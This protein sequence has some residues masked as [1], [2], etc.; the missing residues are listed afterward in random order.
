VISDLLH[1]ILG[2]PVTLRLSG[3][4]NESFSE[5]LENRQFSLVFALTFTF[6]PVYSRN[7]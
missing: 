7:G 3:F 5:F 2:S 6:S 1:E 4:G